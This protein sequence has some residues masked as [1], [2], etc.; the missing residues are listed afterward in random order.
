M[1][2]QQHGRSKAI[3][4][5]L[6][7][8]HKAEALKFEAEA[9]RAR[10]EA[11]QAQVSLDDAQIDLRQKLRIEEELLA[12]D[13]YHETYR[14]LGEISDSSVKNCIDKLTFWHRTKPGC[15][16]EIVFNSPG[17][18]V[19]AGMDLFDYIQE[20]R[21]DGH[22]ILTH[23][24]GHM[25]SMGGILLQAGEVRSMG[26]ESYILIHEVSTWAAG[27][28]GEIEDEYNFLK[29]ISE[30]VVNIFASR[31]K[32]AGENGTA[33]APITAAQVRKNWNRTDWW[34][35]SA[36]ALRLGIVDILR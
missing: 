2:E 14:F 9:L 1:T 26:K 35:D 7:L 28:V 21:R 18:G 30:R 34:I 23:G 33:S 10:T 36:D 12:L 3:E 11:A 8:K 31:A 24:R 27:K 6:V 15:Q 17:G 29:K 19:F 4:D 25:A 22:R 13:A 5:A 32:E 20:L 16:M